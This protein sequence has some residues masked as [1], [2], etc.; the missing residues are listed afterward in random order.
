ML[1]NEQ[2]GCMFSCWGTSYY[3]DYC[4]YPNFL[5]LP[6]SWKE[7]LFGSPTCTAKVFQ[8]Q[9]LL[10]HWPWIQW[11][12]R[13][14]YGGRSIAP[15]KI[16]KHS[17]L[18]LYDPELSVATCS[19]LFFSTSVATLLRLEM[20]STQ[21]TS[22]TLR[23]ALTTENTI[24]FLAQCVQEDVLGN[25]DVFTHMCTNYNLA[26]ALRQ[27]LSSSKKIA[28]AGTL[29]AATVREVDG[30]STNAIHNDARHSQSTYSKLEFIWLPCKNYI[31]KKALEVHRS[32]IADPCTSKQM[33][34][35][36]YKNKVR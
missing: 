14:E 2:H 9:R 1:N 31:T 32:T 19:H 8:V 34:V 27:I 16:R 5:V 4:K 35:Y 25:Q 22:A 28:T 6:P 30:S 23:C 17:L 33:L 10:C 11:P 13:I 3:G 20:R 36:F 26:R 24:K 12:W 15:L 29:L 18:R 7:E 21:Y